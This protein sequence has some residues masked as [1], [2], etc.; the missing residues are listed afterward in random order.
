MHLEKFRLDQIQNG[1]LLAITHFHMADIL[2]NR[3]RWLVLQ[4][5]CIIQVLKKWNS[6]RGHMDKYNYKMLCI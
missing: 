5:F 4:V 2:E 1:R 6:E 3:A